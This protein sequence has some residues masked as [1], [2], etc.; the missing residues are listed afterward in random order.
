V[1]AEVQR[2]AIQ[3]DIQKKQADMQLDAEKTRAE[4]DLKR[5][6]L[7]RN[8]DRER[9]RMEA[10]VILRAAKIQAEHGIPIDINAIFAMMQRNREGMMQ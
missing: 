9:D 4:L 6:Q 5:E 7:L 10:D 8:D 3:A 1:L 2:E